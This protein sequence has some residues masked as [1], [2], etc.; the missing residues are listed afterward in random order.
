MNQRQDRNNTNERL[1]AILLPVGQEPIRQQ[2]I[3]KSDLADY[4]EL[5]CGDLQL[6]ALD[7]PSASLYC[8]DAGK[9][10][11]LPVNERATALLWAHNRAFRGRDVINGPAFIV[12]PAD[13][14]GDDLTAPADLVDLLFHTKRYRVQVQ[15]SGDARWAGNNTVFTDWLEAYRHGL[16][17]AQRWT[18]VEEVRVIPDLD[19]E[20][21]ERWYQLGMQNRWIKEADDPAFTR[22]SFVGCYSVDELAEAIGHGNWTV[23]TAFYYRDLCFINQVEGGDEWLTIR[24]GIAFESMTLGPSIENGRFAPLVQRLLTASRQQCQSLKY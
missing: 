15:V 19:E 6:I 5:V 16:D 18:L 2:Q 23:G 21:L 17:L 3:G 1:T 7:R 11:N 8:N 13:P 24:H 10:L 12:G 14:D 20:L 22:G 4:R 9:L